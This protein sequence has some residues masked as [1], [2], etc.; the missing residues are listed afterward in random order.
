MIIADALR[1]PIIA[2][3]NDKKVTPVIA[4]WLSMLDREYSTSND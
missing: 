1:M 4:Q 2:V 3:Q